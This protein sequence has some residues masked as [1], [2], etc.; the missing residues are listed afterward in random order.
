MQLVSQH[1]HITGCIPACL[2]TV[3][4]VSFDEANRLTGR[5]NEELLAALQAAGLD[6]NVRIPC[7]ITGLKDAIL[8]VRYDIG[9]EAYMHTVVWDVEQQK[10]LDPWEERPHDSY[11][12]GLCLVYELSRPGV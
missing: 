12:E 2:A 6:V 3:L 11:Q 9:G 7:P 5:T 10:V 1:P 8:L 4:G